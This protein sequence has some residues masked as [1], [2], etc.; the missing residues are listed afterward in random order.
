M[1]ETHPRQPA[2]GALRL[3]Q[4]FVNSNDIEAGRDAWATVAELRA[5]L[6][7]HELL[8]SDERVSDADLGR[9][10]EMREALRVLLLVNNNG[11]INREVVDRLNRAAERASLLAH[12]ESDGSAQL[13]PGVA[14]VDG[15]IARILAIVFEAMTV[16]TWVR[17]KACRND[18]CRW[19]FYDTS[20]NQGGV[21]C[22]MALC[23]SR[24]KART[25]R[26]RQRGDPLST[27]D[28]R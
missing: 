26:Q 12:F 3:V 25:Y 17:L 13:D 22:S 20:K 14:G 6:V 16:G 7:D 19:A 1:M 28:G 18:A 9:A 11:A 24:I 10:R 2:P 4:A 27:M 5:W 23:G 8:G 15:A 21:W